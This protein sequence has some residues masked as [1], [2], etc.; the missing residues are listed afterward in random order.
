MRVKT[1][2]GIGKLIQIGQKSINRAKIDFLIN[3]IKP[4]F[5]S[6][7]ISKN[8]IKSIKIHFEIIENSAS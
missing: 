5:W 1:K 4:D 3:A 2:K 8:L 6:K 7:L